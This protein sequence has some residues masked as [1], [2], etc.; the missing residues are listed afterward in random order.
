MSATNARDGT[1]PCARAR[2]ASDE[3]RHLRSPSITY[4]THS[5]AQEPAAAVRRT[6]QAHTHSQA[7]HP[8]SPHPRQ[9]TTT[10]TNHHTTGKT[11]KLPVYTPLVCT[12]RTSPASSPQ[13][14]CQMLM[15]Y[16]SHFRSDPPSLATT[17]LN[18][19]VYKLTYRS[20]A[21]GHLPLVIAPGIGVPMRRREREAGVLDCRTVWTA[22]SPSI[23]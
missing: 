8:L 19:K 12:E 2:A 20:L 7:T 16:A 3:P 13:V 1:A 17:T 14:S 15:L 11:K 9:H 23:A 18:K 6:Q 5:T 10:P 21:C 22:G 4:R